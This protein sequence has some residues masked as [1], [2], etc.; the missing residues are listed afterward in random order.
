VEHPYAAP[1]EVVFAMLCDPQFLDARFLAT[2]AVS[3]EVIECAERPEGDFAVVTRRTVHTEIPGFARR[4]L[5]ANNSMTQTEIWRGSSTDRQGTWRVDADG[6]P[7]STGG[8]TSVESTAEGS[9][10][11]IKGT[12]KVP[13]PLIGGRI[14]RFVFEN[15]K[16]TLDAEHAFGRQWL[17]GRHPA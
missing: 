2:G 9:V 15:A 4:V 14:E 8:L 6:V 1:V 13:V 7:V 3:H 17:A 16:V 5:P 12:I 11:H 10:H